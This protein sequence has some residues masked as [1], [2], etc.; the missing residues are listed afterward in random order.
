MND[1][2]D[3]RGTVPPTDTRTPVPQPVP[4]DTSPTVTPTS[5]ATTEA[6]PTPQAEPVYEEFALPPGTGPHDVAPAPDGTV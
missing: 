5:I 2:G 6:T 3:D 4:L 1:G